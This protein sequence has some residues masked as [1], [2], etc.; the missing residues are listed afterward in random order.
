[1]SNFEKKL[2]TPCHN[3]S[4]YVLEWICSFNEFE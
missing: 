4:W 2:T 3:N 1:M